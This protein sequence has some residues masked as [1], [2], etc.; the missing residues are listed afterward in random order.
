MPGVTDSLQ[1]ADEEARARFYAGQGGDD[2]ILDV[3]EYREGQTDP[4]FAAAAPSAEE[5]DESHDQAAANGEVEGG[6]KTQQ[7]RS[8]AER[9]GGTVTGVQVAL[10]NPPCRSSCQICV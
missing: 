9:I 2:N 3:D 8:A 1:N 7:G 4:S 5:E 10:H 6:P